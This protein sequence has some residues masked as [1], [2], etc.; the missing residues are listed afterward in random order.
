MPSGT[1]SQYQPRVYP[2]MVSL[3]HNELIELKCKFFSSSDTSRISDDLDG[4]IK[5]VKMWVSERFIVSYTIYPWLIVFCFPVVI[6]GVFITLQW[7]HN[8]CDSVSNHQP[9]DCLL[10]RLF[11]RRS[12]KTS[13]LYVI[14]LCVRN[15]PMA[16]EFSAQI[17]SNAENVY[18]WWRHLWGLA[19]SGCPYSPGS[20]FTKMTP[21]YECGNAHYKPGDHLRL[22]MGIHPREY[23]PWAATTK[24]SQCQWSN[25]EQGV[26]GNIVYIMKHNKASNV[27]IFLWYLLCLSVMRWPRKNWTKPSLLRNAVYSSTR[28]LLFL[29]VHSK[30]WNENAATWWR[31][32]ME[33]FPRYW[34][35]VRGIHRSPSK[36]PYKGQ[37][38]GALVFSLICARINDWVNYREA[39]DLR[40]H[41]D[42]YD[43]IVMFWWNCHWPKHELLKDFAK[44]HFRWSL[45]L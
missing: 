44:L 42:H 21:S 36:S 17:A 5:N 16:G 38:R 34:S 27:S 20:I 32:Q 23:R 26:W 25:P 45:L 11:R 2:H 1:L 4:V 15:S 8:G 31:H 22:I 19:W 10:N 33:T 3:G 18:I 29:V 35:F 14:G 30:H 24:L 43:V 7:R 9:H 40:R 37:W 13:K 28:A 41:R 12:K 39:G 6:S